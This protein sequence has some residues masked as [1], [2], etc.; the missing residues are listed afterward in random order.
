MKNRVIAT[1]KSKGLLLCPSHSNPLKGREVR[2]PPHSTSGARPD[3]PRLLHHRTDNWGGDRVG[4]PERRKDDHRTEDLKVSRD[5]DKQEWTHQEWKDPVADD[6]AEDPGFDSSKEFGVPVG[7]DD[8]TKFSTHSSVGAPSRPLP[9]TRL[10][11]RGPNTGPDLLLLP[12]HST[13]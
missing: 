12:R 9:G 1:N 4:G 6:F 13:S 10:P 11:N 8:E 5:R 2:D 7:A 3:V